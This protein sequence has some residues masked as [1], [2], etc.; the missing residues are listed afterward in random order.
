[1]WAIAIIDFGLSPAEARWLT[2]PQ[3]KVL[4]KRVNEKEEAKYYRI[5]MVISA[6]YNVNRDAKSKPITPDQVLGKNQEGGLM[7]TATMLTELHG[8]EVEDGVKSKCQK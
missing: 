6:I 7:E 4:M 1:M 2:L 8:G 3:F 5:A